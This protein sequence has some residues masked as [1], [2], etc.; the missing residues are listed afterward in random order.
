MAFLVS[1]AVS[2]VLPVGAFAL[3]GSLAI[4][5]GIGIAYVGAVYVGRRFIHRFIPTGII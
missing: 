5:G 2:V 3:S 4:A 1:S